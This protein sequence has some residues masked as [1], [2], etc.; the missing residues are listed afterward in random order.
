[1]QLVPKS[2]LVVPQCLDAQQV[3]GVTTCGC[4]MLFAVLTYDMYGVAMQGTLAGPRA[5]L[6]RL[7]ESGS[8]GQ[9][10]QAV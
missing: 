1:M 9:A 4:C 2:N 5:C 8:R 7:E 10:W 6:L 3:F